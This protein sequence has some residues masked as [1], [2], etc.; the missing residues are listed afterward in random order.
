MLHESIDLHTL[1][2]FSHRNVP[3]DT[4]HGSNQDGDSFD[5]ELEIAEIAQSSHAYE[6][7]HLRGS[8]QGM[9]STLD[10]ERGG[11]YTLEANQ[12]PHSNHYDEVGDGPA[13]VTEEQLLGVIPTH[14]YDTPR[15]QGEATQPPLSIMWE[16]AQSYEEPECIS[17][18]K[19]QPSSLMR[20]AGSP[21]D[22]ASKYSDT[23]N[24]HD[25]YD[26]PKPLKKSCE[27]I[28]V[29]SS[30]KVSNNS[31]ALSG[32]GN[33]SQMSTHGSYDHLEQ[34]PLQN[35]PSYENIKMADYIPGQTFPALDSPRS[36]VANK[37]V[38]ISTV[39]K[40]KM[41]PAI[42]SKLFK[43]T[44]ELT[45]TME[46]NSKARKHTYEPLTPHNMEKASM[47]DQAAKSTRSQTWTL[48][49]HISHKLP[50]A[51]NYTPIDLTAVDPKNDYDKL[52]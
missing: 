12:E 29:T 5:R 42:P 6:S 14:E 10:L 8:S 11:R 49:G 51:S 45:R 43:P 15:P 4:Q 26:H 13:P 41:K 1:C 33:S 27:D 20:S 18:I 46:A 2:S 24:M 39:A 16:G 44:T 21:L 37:N 40:V 3:S 35:S 19:N 48:D 28:P 50:R 31:I 9:K 34:L 36:T 22:A 23:V 47:Y 25:G 38:P 32:E 7:V 30:R 52:S 17:G